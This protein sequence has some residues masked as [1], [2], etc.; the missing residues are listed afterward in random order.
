MA[1]A[2]PGLGQVEGR[3]RVSVGLSR[4]SGDPCD[5]LNDFYE[6]VLLMG[7]AREASGMWNFPHRK[8]QLQFQ[9]LK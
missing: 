9:F 3:T 1:K 7:F 8:L 6:L 5:E 2:E 4:G